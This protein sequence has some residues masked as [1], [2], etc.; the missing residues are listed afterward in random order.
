MAK[1]KYL[2]IYRQNADEIIP[3]F[4]TIPNEL[5]ALQ[6]V[7]GGLIEVVYLDEDIICVINEE[8]KINGLR[9]NFAFE[10]MENY[11][12]VVCGDVFFVGDDGLNFKSL[13]EE[14]VERAFQFANKGRYIV[15][16]LIKRGQLEVE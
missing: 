6:G 13:T 2:R 5:E 1:E 10:A 4:E 8:G 3:R 11:W 16:E 14:Q 15:N 9:P 7:V 12:D